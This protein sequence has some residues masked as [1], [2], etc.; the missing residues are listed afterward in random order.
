MV[1]TFFHCGRVPQEKEETVLDKQLPEYYLV[2]LGTAQDAGY[3][4]AGCEKEC[5]K[6]YWQGKEAVRYTSCLGIVDKG[7]GKAWVFDATPD[8]KFQMQELLQNGEELAGIFLTHAHIGHYTGLMHLGREVMGANAVPVYAM[9]KMTDFLTHNGP[10]SQL[11]ELSNISLQPLKAD[12]TIVLN[13]NFKVTPFLVPHRD[14]FSETVGYT[15]EGPGKRVLFIPDINKW[16]V[17]H[18]DIVEEIKKVDLAFLDAT[19]YQNGEIP[20][21]DMSE[22]PHPF[23]EESMARFEVLSETERAKVHFIHF[24]HTNPV[25]RNTREKER[26]LEKGFKVAEDFMVV[27]LN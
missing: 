24:N 26:V 13:K 11:V 2:V 27:D 12:S 7:S 21:R 9:P 5:C 18:N 25:M 8:F 1:M 20:G 10:W 17:W 3:P 22:I 23:M 16:D 14:E 15:I 4:Q 6:A 19:F